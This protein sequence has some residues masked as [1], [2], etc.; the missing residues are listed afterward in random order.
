MALVESELPGRW[1]GL[2]GELPLGVGLYEGL[3]LRWGLCEEPLPSQD[4]W[5]AAGEKAMCVER[6]AVAELGSGEQLLL[7]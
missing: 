2:Q 5:A 1:A 4:A 3:W 7:V 6:A